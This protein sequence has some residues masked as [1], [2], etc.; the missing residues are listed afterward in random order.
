MANL[1][2]QSTCMQCCIE[3]GLGDNAPKEEFDL[4]DS[5]YY[6]WQCPNGHEVHLVLANKR[7]ELLLE[8]GLRA[9]RD[10]YLREFVVSFAGALERFYEFGL[11][12]LLQEESNHA[13]TRFSK[14]DALWEQIPWSERQL[15]AFQAVWISNFG[16]LPVTLSPGKVKIRNGVVHNGVLPTKAKAIEFCQAAYDAI[17]DNASLLL[18]KRL[19]EVHWVGHFATYVAA[20]DA[21]DGKKI[22]TTQTIVTPFAL[23]LA[24]ELQVRANIAQMIG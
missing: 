10:G 2:I 1:K 8:I 17:F 9:A 24:P 3:A 21:I 4:V 22:I 11:R 15:G 14:F 19:P 6:P 13:A 20:R 5:N 12:V 18:E 23:V 7:F 16:K